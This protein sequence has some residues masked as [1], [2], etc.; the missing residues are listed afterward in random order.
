MSRLILSGGMVACFVLAVGGCTIENCEQGA[1]CEKS[2]P[3]PEPPE[4]GGDS[5]VSAPSQTDQCLGYCDRLS[6]CGA[7]QANDFD[8]CV[9]ACKVRFEKLPKQTADLCACIP[10]S[11]CEDVVE[12]RCSD[13]SG[14][15]GTSSSTGSGGG[16]GKGGSSSTGGSSSGGSSQSNGGTATT[17][18]HSTS[19]GA[20]ASGGSATSGGAGS[21]A[22]PAEAGSCGAMS[23]AAGDSSGDAGGI[24]AGGEGAAQACTCDCDCPE[25]QTCEYGYCSG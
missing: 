2:D 16:P 10:S 17:G 7:P 15:G 21:G 9:K 1:V 14:S 25:P 22:A 4:I 5:N 19:G 12:G 24:G 3:Q 20:P 6:V 13:D 23:S 11:R 8:G 18:T